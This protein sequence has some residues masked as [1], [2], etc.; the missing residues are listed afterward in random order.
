MPGY[1][2]NE[3]RNT[4]TG[5]EKSASKGKQGAHGTGKVKTCEDGGKSGSPKFKTAA[6]MVGAPVVGELEVPGVSIV[7]GASAP[8]WDGVKKGSAGKPM[9]GGSGIKKPKD[10]EDAGR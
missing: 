10:A 8:G 9:G 1:F 6:E 7:K 4:A 3:N 2:P 5:F